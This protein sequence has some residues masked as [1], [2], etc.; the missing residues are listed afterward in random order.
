MLISRSRT[1]QL[2]DW[3]ESLFVQMLQINSHSRRAGTKQKSK[4]R[5]RH[6]YFTQ[7]FETGNTIAR[8]LR[9]TTTSASQMEL[10]G[11]SL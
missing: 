1:R 5:T 11:V 7:T 4:S 10:V 2:L 3:I 6:K 8:D 9:D